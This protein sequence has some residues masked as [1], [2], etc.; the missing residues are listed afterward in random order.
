MRNRK[1][2]LGMEG[3]PLLQKK[4]WCGAGRGKSCHD[5]QGR[6]TATHATRGTPKKVVVAMA[7]AAGLPWPR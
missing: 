4:C 6:A 5:A 2:P 3:D 7:K 1:H